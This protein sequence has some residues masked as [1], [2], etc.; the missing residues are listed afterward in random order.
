MEAAE[1]AW[2]ETERW[3]TEMVVNPMF[4]ITLTLPPAW[5]RFVRRHGSNSPDIDAARAIATAINIA[6][7]A[8]GYYRKGGLRH[9]VAGWLETGE[10]AGK[11]HFHGVANNGS[12][13]ADGW[14]RSLAT[15]GFAHAEAKVEFLRELDA[16]IVYSGREGEN[17]LT[18][19]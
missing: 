10:I 15:L 17:P 18:F 4:F 6:R 14:K 3:A 2:I 7:K 13:I 11:L 12:G 1:R 9:R 16:A 8:D 5:V 19:T